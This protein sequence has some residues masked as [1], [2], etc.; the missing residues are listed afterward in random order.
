[1]FLAITYAL[2]ISDIDLSGLLGY[3]LCMLLVSEN[4]MWFAIEASVINL[5]VITV[6][7]YVKVVHPIWSK[8]KLRR[9]SASGEQL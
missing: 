5:S 1:V 2:K 4:L 8:N 3:W 9:C 6:E 7:R